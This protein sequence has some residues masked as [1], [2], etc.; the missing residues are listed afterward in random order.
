MKASLAVFLGLGLAGQSFAANLYC[1]GTELKDVRT[2]KAL[3]TFT[4]VEDY[5]GVDMACAPTLKASTN[6]LYCKGTELKDLRTGKVLRTFTYS[7]D[8][9]GVDMACAPTL[10]ASQ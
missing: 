4:Y 9:M 7:E 3:R 5:M 6:E 2:G 1:K 8:Y 10:K